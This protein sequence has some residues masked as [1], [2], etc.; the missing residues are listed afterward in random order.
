MFQFKAVVWAGIAL[1][2]VLVAG[3]LAAQENRLY[4]GGSIGQS[5]VKVDT[6]GLSD[7]LRAVGLGNSGVSSDN[8]DTGWKAFVG[9]RFTPNV[10]IEGGY[11]ELGKIAATTTI[12]SVNGVAVTPTNLKID[13]KAT[14]GFH[15]AGVFGFPLGSQFSAFGKLGGYFMKTKISVSAAGVS[16]GDTDHNTGLLFGLGAGFDFSRNLGLR[17]EW[18]RFKDVGD[19]DKTFEGDVDLLSIGLVYRF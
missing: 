6:G 11:V 18:E 13:M 12:T 14:E 5:R 10:A 8:S 2:F 4:V 16:A 1:G 17:A 3:P 7:D 19:K 15:V 9:Y